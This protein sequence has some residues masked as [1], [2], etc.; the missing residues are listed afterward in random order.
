MKAE[1]TFCERGRFAI[2][3]A[4]GLAVLCL[5]GWSTAVALRHVDEGVL[6]PAS[7]RG[8][9]FRRTLAENLRLTRRGVRG[10]DFVSCRVCR[11]EK[12]KKGFLTLGGMNVL[13][14]E[15]LSV[16]IPP[17][18]MGGGD[19][20]GVADRK[21]DVADIVS[22]LGISDGFLASRGMQAKFSGLRVS[23]LVVDRLADGEVRQAV[24]RA[25]SANAVRGGLALSGCEVAMPSGEMSRVGKAMLAKRGHRLCLSW[26]GGERYLN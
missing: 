15:D 26:A 7:S 5:I 8:K 12:R 9:V 14:L 13:V 25:K 4:A 23:H 16:V 21:G 20:T 24:F 3:A 22:R 2:L 18:E 6:E 17:E 11:L 19:K 10:V 1:R